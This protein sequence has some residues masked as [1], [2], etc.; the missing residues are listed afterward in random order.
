M[1]SATTAHVHSLLSPEELAGIRAARAARMQTI[2]CPPQ[3]PFLEAV[4]SIPVIGSIVLLTASLSVVGPSAP[5]RYAAVGASAAVVIVL[6]AIR[7]F[8]KSFWNFLSAFIGTVF[9]G[10]SGPGTLISYL[11]WK[12]YVA[13]GT[14]VFLTW[15][16]WMLLGFLFGLAGWAA[17]LAVYHGFTKHIPDLI[18]SVIEKFSPKK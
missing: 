16:V 8:E 17:A 14:Y 10:I 6:V 5:D 9:A 11:S 12:G 18:T 1:Q 4:T 15:H 2:S 13:E 3:H 7:Q